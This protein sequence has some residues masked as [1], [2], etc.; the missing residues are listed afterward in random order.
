MRLLETH[1]SVPPWNFPRLK[2]ATRPKIHP[3][4]GVG[5]SQ[6]RS[7]WGHEGR[8]RAPCRAKPEAELSMSQLRAWGKRMAATFV[9]GQVL[10]PLLSDVPIPRVLPTTCPGHSSLLASAS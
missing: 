10:P 5:L 2:E 9:L 1:S 7:L 6:G 4:S 8:L 3:L